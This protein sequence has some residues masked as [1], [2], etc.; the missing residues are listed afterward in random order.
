MGHNYQLVGRSFKM[1]RRCCKNRRSGHIPQL[2]NINLV[3]IFSKLSIRKL[4][5]S[6]SLFATINSCTIYWKYFRFFSPHSYL[7]IHIAYFQNTY[8]YS[9]KYIKSLNFKSFS[10]PALLPCSPL[11]FSPPVL[12][13]CSL[14]F[15]SAWNSPMRVHDK[16]FYLTFFKF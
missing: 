9:F 4:Y 5:S 8:K 7:R 1:W 16:T 11:L 2:M 15:L 14:P 10:P 6:I 12:P 13:S 3:R